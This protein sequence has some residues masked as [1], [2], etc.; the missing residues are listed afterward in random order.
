MNIH[1]TKSKLG[2]TVLMDKILEDLHTAGAG[3]MYDNMLMLTNRI[4][5]Y[6]DYNRIMGSKEFFNMVYLLLNR[7]P[8]NLIRVA[9]KEFDTFLKGVEKDTFDNHWHW[10]YPEEMVQVNVKTNYNG[11]VV[12]IEVERYPQDLS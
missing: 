3:G 1:I 5:A 4:H 7:K 2:L 9:V 10:T 11:H 12:A 8:F 6:K